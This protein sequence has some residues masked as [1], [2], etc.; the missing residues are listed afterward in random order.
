LDQND[1]AVRGYI[2]AESERLGVSL[3]EANEKVQK[4]Y[5][6]RQHILLDGGKSLKN[7][8]NAEENT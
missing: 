2:Q 6:E 5:A 4:S 7:L 3:A 1:D 8:E